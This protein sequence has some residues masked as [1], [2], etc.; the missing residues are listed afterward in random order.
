MSIKIKNTENFDTLRQTGGYY[1]DKTGFLEKFLKSPADASLF[2]RPRRFG[3]TLF[4]S[5]LASFFNVT[6][7]SRD[8]FAGLKVA[9]NENLCREWMNQYPVIFLT[10]KSVDTLSYAK[11]L[12]R[13]Q[14]LISDVCTL[15]YGL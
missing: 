11:A 3:K 7:S 13:I 8:L 12:E 9:E 14:I 5:M 1:V 6:K 10:L 4:M 2:T 15:T